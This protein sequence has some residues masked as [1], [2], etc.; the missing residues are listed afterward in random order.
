MGNKDLA[1]QD[2]AEGL[3][4][5]SSC[6]ASLLLLFCI[7]AY[8]L[9]I[10][11]VVT[12][13]RR[14]APPPTPVNL[15]T[16]SLLTL[17]GSW[18][19]ANFHWL[20]DDSISR[21][22]TSNLEILLLIA[23]TF[24]IYG[25]AALLLQRQ[26]QAT[27]YTNILRL[28]WIGAILAGLIFVL[29]PAMLSHDL[30]VYADYGHTMITHG[31]NLYFSPPIAFPDGSLRRLDDW[32]SVPAAYGPLWL[33]ICSLCALVAGDDPV[34]SLLTFRLL[35][36]A[37]HL[38]NILLVMTILRLSGRSQRVFALGTLLYAW[39]PLVVL[40]SCLGAHNDIFMVTFIL[41]GILL[42]IRA[43]QQGLT[44]PRNYVLPL[45]I[46][47]LPALI[48]FITLPI[49]LF[50][51]VLLA[52]KALY[53]P[54][55]VEPHWRSALLTLLFAS[56]TSTCI[57]LVFYAPFWIGHSIVDIA[58]SFVAPPSAQS[59]E[60]SILRAIG[61]WIALHGMPS[62]SSL[63]YLPLSLLRQHTVWSL[64]SIVTLAGG[65]IIGAIAL[66]RSPT[67]QT[68]ILATLATSGAMFIVIPWFFAWYVTLLVGLAVASFIAP[69]KPIGRALVAFALTFS[70]T[71]FFTYVIYSSPLLG[72]SAVEECLRA[73]G[74]PVLVFFISLLVILTQ[75]RRVF[76][77]K[78]YAQEK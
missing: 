16:N 57:I 65:L 17:W 25:L 56:L 68:M 23:L 60:N 67:I 5:A 74:I 26:S 71:A 43:Q 35:G 7:L 62:Q 50:F 54:T 8:I 3:H 31:A 61:G 39:N 33:Y 37:A 51:L 30:F 72:N 44:Q 42:C 70:A 49:T 77:D 29:T 58:H 36:F 19:P 28:T 12:P 55:S 4:K 78:S 6:P 76:P 15:P 21:F 27:N 9:C 63:A 53:R 18:L 38:L 46:F 32:K 75:K 14:F 10:L 2:D 73:F 20:K 13:L 69:V 1:G 52:R 66:W 47:T 45:A 41:L 11:M 64:I 22:S 34:R 24:A 48:K 59:T 40:E